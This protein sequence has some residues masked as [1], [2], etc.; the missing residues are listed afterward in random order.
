MPSYI[1]SNQPG[2]PTAVGAGDS[3]G[4]TGP[5][6]PPLA[7]GSPPPPIA[8][9]GQVTVRH[10]YSRRSSSA[11]SMVRSRRPPPPSGPPS[12]PGCRGRWRVSATDSPPRPV[13]PTGDGRGEWRARRPTESDEHRVTAAGPSPRPAGAAP[14]ETESRTRQ[15]SLPYHRPKAGSTLRA[16]LISRSPTRP[17]EVRTSAPRRVRYPA[18]RRSPARHTGCRGPRRA[19]GPEGGSPER[20][21]P[22]I[23]VP[24]ADPRLSNSRYRQLLDSVDFTTPLDF[25]RH[26]G[27][28]ASGTPDPPVDRRRI[29]RRIGMI[30]PSTV[31]RRRAILQVRLPRPAWPGQDPTRRC[32]RSTSSKVIWLSPALT[33]RQTPGASPQ[34][35]GSSSSTACTPG[36]PWTD[37]RPSA[38]TI[39]VEPP[40]GGVC[41]EPPHVVHRAPQSQPHGCRPYDTRRRPTQPARRSS[42]HPAPTGSH[43]RPSR[44]AGFPDLSPAGIL[45]PCSKC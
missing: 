7:N 38:L 6:C 13:P 26:R 23:P 42:R 28:V 1:P 40:K 3:V 17:A 30:L 35:G 15:P 27:T 43:R 41:R 8:P 18:T 10:Q 4:L 25:H 9:T 22:P 11:V 32:C 44:S 36:R 12:P 37:T 2:G 34:H 33:T 24:A 39:A 19:P 14:K 31:G 20:R 5:T 16:R 21:T 29:P 45:R